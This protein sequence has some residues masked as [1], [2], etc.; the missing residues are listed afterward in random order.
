MSIKNRIVIATIKSW[1]IANAIKFKNIHSEEFETLIITKKEDLNLNYIKD[2][3]PKYIFFP[4]WSWIIKNDIYD[5]FDCIV[6]HMTDLPFGRGGSPLQNLIINK[7]YNTKI[8]AIKVDGEI[9]TGKI[10]FKEDF[11]IGLG[12]ADE[13]FQRISELIFFKM[14]PNILKNNI[15]PQE[16]TGDI[17]YFNRRT[18]EDSDISKAS[19]NNFDDLY[20]FIRMLDGE[21]YPNAFLKLGKFKISFKEISEKSDKVTG[22]FEIEEEK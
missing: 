8:S 6:F 19:L 13:I 22:R 2:F 9:D 3:D 18:P 20:D 14:I 10:Y 15:I 17:T 21:G 11:Y 16:Q 1:N 7:I 4:H 5:N 12:N